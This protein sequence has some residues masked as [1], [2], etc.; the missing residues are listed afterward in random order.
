[1]WFSERNLST[2]QARAEPELGLWAE[3]ILLC[4]KQWDAW[5]ETDTWELPS[6]QLNSLQEP[7]VSVYRNS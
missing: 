1:M 4:R 5:A 2:Q 3:L 7:E 6:G